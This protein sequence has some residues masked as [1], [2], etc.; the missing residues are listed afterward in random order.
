MAFGDVLILAENT[1]T[2]QLTAYPT[3]SYTP[4]AGRLI[5]AG[6]LIT[7]S[8]APGTPTLTG[9]GLTWSLIDE[10]GYSTLAAPT[11][12][13]SVFQ[14]PVISPSSGACEIAS[15]SGTLT[16]CT[17]SIV[18]LDLAALVGGIVQAQK[19]GSDVTQTSALVPMNPFAD[20]GNLALAF[21]VLNNQQAQTE[22]PNWNRISDLPGTAPATG[23]LSQYFLGDDGDASASWGSVTRWAM[24]AL[25]IK[26]QVA[27]AQVWRRQVPMMLMR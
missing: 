3:S 27:P 14:A 7:A 5:V 15:S 20:A 1:N 24:I 26:A 4:T 17:W 21:S 25:E 10:I 23:F 22:R 2:S 6:T 18:E 19:A 9:N 12:L 8:S 13:L 16:S 11:K